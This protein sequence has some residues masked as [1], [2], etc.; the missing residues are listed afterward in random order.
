M[1]LSKAALSGGFPTLASAFCFHAKGE[2][3]HLPRSPGKNES[4][5]WFRGLVVALW[6][7]WAADQR[8]LG[9]DPGDLEFELQCGGT[10]R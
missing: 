9:P 4:D 1:L 8:G 3:A 10:P 7:R 5:L 2:P 6:R